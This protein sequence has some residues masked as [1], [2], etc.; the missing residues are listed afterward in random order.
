MNSEKFIKLL[1]EEIDNL[2]SAYS[3]GKAGDTYIGT[4]IEKLPCSDEIKI[5]ILDIVNEA[6]KENIY[7]LLS[8]L[9]GSSQ[10][11]GEQQIYKITDENQNIVSGELDSEFYMQVLEN[12]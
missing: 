3:K 1:K 6:V 8:T 10:L 4:K 2:H 9:E 5:E 7:V 11:A 12:E